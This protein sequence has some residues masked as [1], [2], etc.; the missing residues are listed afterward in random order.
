MVSNGLDT[1]DSHIYEQKLSSHA[2]QGKIIRL[3]EFA[4]L[5]FAILR[6]Y[7]FLFPLAILTMIAGINTG[8]SYIFFPHITTSS[9]IFIVIG[10]IG[11]FTCVLMCTVLD[12]GYL[13][14]DPEL[15][16]HEEDEEGGQPPRRMY[17]SK[18]HTYPE[19][20]VVHDGFADLCVKGYDHF[21][22]VLGNVIG[23]NNI[24]FFYSVFAFYVMNVLALVFS[25]VASQSMGIPV[26]T[27]LPN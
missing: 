24:I 14:R 23:R 6:G 17:C 13:V 9:K 21:C 7:Y 3:G 1:A 2:H 8:F 20:R 26:P 16:E 27:T 10:G 18:C 12:P 4:G 5:K 22:I 11:L 15:E 25:I 19:D